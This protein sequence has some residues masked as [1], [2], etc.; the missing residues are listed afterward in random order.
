MEVELKKVDNWT[1]TAQHALQKETHPLPV[2]RGELAD[3][4]LRNQLFQ[5]FR[6]AGKVGFVVFKFDSGG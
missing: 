4:V 2:V 3:Q 6:D 1:R 5:H